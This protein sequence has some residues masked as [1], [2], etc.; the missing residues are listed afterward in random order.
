MRQSNRINNSI[1]TLVNTNILI[2]GANHS[3]FN[4]SWGNSDSDFQA[5]I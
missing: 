2:E 3:Q 4:S 5:N 1:D